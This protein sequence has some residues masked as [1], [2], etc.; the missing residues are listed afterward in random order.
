MISENKDDESKQTLERVI[1]FIDGSNFY[2]SFKETFELVDVDIVDFKKLVNFLKG[3][4]LLIGV[5]YYNA[6]LD[7]GYNETT[8]RKQQQFFAELRNIPDFHVVLCNMRKTIGKDGKPDYRVKGDDISLGVDMVSFAYE[9][10]YDTAI[11]VSGDGDF[12]PAI[13]KVQKLGKKVENAYFY[14]SRS[15]LLKQICNHSVA[16]DEILEEKCFKDEKDK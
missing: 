14:I 13:L 9:N 7:R 1:I 12:K 8:Y 15:G 16:L 2:L 10:L 4:R 3:N 5:Y 11:L 6:P